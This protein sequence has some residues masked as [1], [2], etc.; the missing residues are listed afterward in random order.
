MLSKK[1]LTQSQ[2]I[3]YAGVLSAIAIILQFVELPYP[4]V[5]WLKIDLSEVIVLIA[6]VI[7]IW[8]AIIVLT[9]KAWLS[10]LINPSADFIGHLAMFLGSITLVVPY[11]FCS[12]KIGKI[13]SLVIAVLV[14]TV[15]MT[16]LNYVY[17]TPAYLDSSFSEM[18]GVT[19]QLE[20]GTQKMMEQGKFWL[21]VTVSYPV[22]IA[23][24]YFPFNLLKGA[25]V[26]VIFYFLAKR[27]DKEQ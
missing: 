21:D 20:F 12:K 13:P 11:Y 3:A 6:A 10:L 4:L 27:L 17:I 5:P 26:S 23:A 8:L 22:Y 15:A 2:F 9:V 7:N 19:Q 18:A 14:F 1:K 24:M 16:A 25:I